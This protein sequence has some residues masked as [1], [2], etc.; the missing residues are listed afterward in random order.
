MIVPFS[1]AFENYLR[2]LKSRGGECIEKYFLRNPTHESG[3]LNFIS[4]VYKAINMIK[5]YVANEVETRAWSLPEG[6]SIMSAA[7]VISTDMEKLFNYAD[8]VAFADFIENDGDLDVLR[9]DRKLRPQGKK[10]ILCD[11]RD[12]E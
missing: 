1:V 4:S 12:L 9:A 8:V 7:K 6:S 11:G 2:S 3:V 5:Y 10:Y